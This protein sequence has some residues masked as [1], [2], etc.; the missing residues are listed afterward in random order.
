MHYG[1]RVDT[2]Q[3]ALLD[4]LADAPGPIV[5]VANEVRLG[6]VPGNAMAQT[7]RNHAGRTSQ[8]VAGVAG[9]VYFVAAGLPMILKR[10]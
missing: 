4:S 6:I 5:P 3:E 2:A 9:R 8:A 10:E 7:F 1:L